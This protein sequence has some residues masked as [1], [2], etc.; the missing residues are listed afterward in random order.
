MPADRVGNGS[1]GLPPFP[2]GW[3]FVA[4]RQAL[5]K[6]TLIEK[7]WMG[8]RIVAWRDDA[9]RVSVAESVCPH[10][11]SAL[12]PS[13]GGRVRDGRLVCPFHGYEFDVSGQCVATP[14]AP[15]PKTAKLRSFATREVLGIVFAWWGLDGRPPQWG[16]P[17]DSPAGA[18]WCELA[19]RTLRFRGHPQET[20]ENAVDMAHLRYVHGY[21]NVGRVGSVT[22]DGAH[23]VSRF[24]FKRTQRVAGITDLRFDVSA[25]AHVIGLGYSFVEF[26]ERSIGMDGRLWVLATPVDGT[27]I[28]LVLV[29]QL[30][31]IRKPK[32][33]IV[34]LRFLPPALRTE[35]MNRLMLYFQRHDVMQ[36]VEVW[37]RKRYR[38]RPALCASD[39]EIG[40]YR[41]Y[42]RQFY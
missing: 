5:E 15:P 29:G 26:H 13:A 41:R 21:D 28:D 19:F 34:G 36:D 40:M 3:Y 7:T 17:E 37:S 27:L 39:G 22:V 33:P 4:S 9:G 32:R 20:S 12:G 42:C 30:R 35:A 25:T 14:F 23:L 18:D 24:D 16:L 11:G 10:L 1:G 2:E 8:K 6:A 38:D 31:K